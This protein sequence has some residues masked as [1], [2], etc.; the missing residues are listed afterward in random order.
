MWE[1][2]DDNGLW[3]AFPEECNKTIEERFFEKQTQF[4]LGSPD[5]GYSYNLAS[6]CRYHPRNKK[7]QKMRRTTV[8]WD[9]SEGG[10][11][12]GGARLGVGGAEVGHAL[13]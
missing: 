10:R 3:Q 12:S 6:P 8:Y 2:L 7:A 5:L 11:G 4:T 9:T 1:Y 13:G